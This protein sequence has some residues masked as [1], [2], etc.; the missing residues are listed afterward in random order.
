MK[1]KL[2]Y[3]HCVPKKDRVTKSIKKKQ[4]LSKKMENHQYSLKLT[5]EAW[6]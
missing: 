2:K 1:A 5:P 6:N 4:I 3:M